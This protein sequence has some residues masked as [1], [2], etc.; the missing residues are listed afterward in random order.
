AVTGYD[1]PIEGPIPTLPKNLMTPSPPS[2]DV[3]LIARTRRLAAWLTSGRGAIVMVSLVTLVGFALRIWHLDTEPLHVDEIRQVTNVQAPWGDLIQLSYGLQQPPVDYLIGKAFVTVL[4]ATDFVQRLPAALFGTAS[5]GLVGLILIRQGQRI[6]AVFAALFM[7]ISP[8]LIELSQFARP[9]ALPIF[10]VIA[11]V[12]VYQHRQLGARGW[13]TTALFAVVASMAMLS[14]ATMPMIALAG[15]GLVAL[16]RG[17]AKISMTQPVKL[18]RSDPLGLLVLPASFLLVWV[19]STLYLNSATSPLSSCWTCDKWGRVANAVENFGNFG[20]RALRPSSLALLILASVG[21]LVFAKVRSALAGSALIWLPLLITAPAFALIQAIVLPPNTFF[22]YRYIAFLPAGLA[23]YLA[24]AVTALLRGIDPKQRLL[25][26][27]ATL[28]VLVVAASMAVEMVSTVKTQAQ[29]LDLADWRST[30]DHIEAI[31]VEGDVIVSIDTRPLSPESKFGFMAAPRYY[32][33]TSTF[34]SPA[35]AIEHP[36]WAIEAARYHFVLFVP[37]MA[38][39]W[40]VPAGWDFVEFSEMMIFST[41][42]LSSHEAR[43]DAWWVMTQQ[44]R[45]DVAIHT[46]AAAAGLEHLAGTSLYPWEQV[47]REQAAAIGQLE[48]AEELLVEATGG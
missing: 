15:L 10:L 18:V 8:L 33:G 25:R 1:G 7:A 20:E 40:V 11:T 43:M 28:L 42:T 48:F 38:E 35:R 45:P 6:A 5:V 23:V 47:V 16:I 17:L 26:R 32:D 12:A 31:E 4:P 36:E 9:Y 34:V 46:Q 2:V 3:G 41:P 22:A 21:V 19:P 30:A 13:K 39:G 37:K 24:I 14:R 44:L 27:T 29:T